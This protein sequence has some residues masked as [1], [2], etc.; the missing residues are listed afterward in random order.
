MGFQKGHAKVGGRKAG[1][2]NRINGDVRALLDDLGCNPVLGMARIAMDDS[3]D[4]RIRM[5]LLAKLMR[6]VYPPLKAVEYPGAVGLPE[7]GPVVYPSER[8]LRELS[9]TSSHGAA[10]VSAVSPESTDP[11]QQGKKSDETLQA[12][13]TGSIRTLDLARMERRRFGGRSVVL[14]FTT[15]PNP[16]RRCSNEGFAPW[17]CRYCL[18]VLDNNLPINVARIDRQVVFARRRMHV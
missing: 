16:R 10:A 7:E 3:V 18:V 2:P 17:G 1:V 14:F 9:K 4:I 12:K 13:K 8:I 6:L 15:S 11:E 5:R